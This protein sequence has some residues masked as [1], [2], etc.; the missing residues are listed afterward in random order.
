MERGTDKVFWDRWSKDLLPAENINLNQKLGYT[1][2][3][4][5][6]KTIPTIKIMKIPVTPSSFT[7][8]CNPFFYP[9]PPLPPHPLAALSAPV[10]E[11]AFPRILW[12]W[13]IQYV[14][15][16]LPFSFKVLI[17]IHILSCFNS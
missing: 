8:L 13:E 9:S 5:I 17:F 4:C 16:V 1:Y 6:H 10:D 2:S 15:F 14:L 11:F 7:H 12:G 3:I